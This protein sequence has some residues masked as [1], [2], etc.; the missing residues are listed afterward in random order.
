MRARIDSGMGGI[1]ATAKATW[2]ELY[3]VFG[4]YKKATSRKDGKWT[5]HGLRF[6]RFYAYIRKT[7]FTGHGR[8]LEPKIGTKRRQ[9]SAPS[10]MWC[11]PEDAA[12]GCG[13]GDREMTHKPH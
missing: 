7:H 13:L 8:S 2:R 4:A 12:F 9:K 11:S 3:G 10:S 6:D 1:I 5:I